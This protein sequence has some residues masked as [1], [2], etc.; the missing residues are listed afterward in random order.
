MLEKKKPYNVVLKDS[1]KG[2]KLMVGWFGFF[3]K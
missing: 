3:F 2:T 1:L